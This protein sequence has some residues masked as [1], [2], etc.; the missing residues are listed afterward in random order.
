MGSNNGYGDTIITTTDDEGEVHLFE[1]IQD[2]ELEGKQYALMVY[3]GTETEYDKKSDEEK[4]KAE[5]EGYDED[6]VVMKVSTEDGAEVFESVED[7]A[8]FE[9]VVQYIEKLMEEDDEDEIVIDL[10]ELLSDTEGNEN[11]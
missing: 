9:K 6:V 5:E 4:A 11:N 2:L 3:L 1:K 10:E 8:E 7:E